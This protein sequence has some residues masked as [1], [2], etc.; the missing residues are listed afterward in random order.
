[1]GKISVV[2]MGGAE[3]E[4]GTIVLARDAKT[5]FTA[6]EVSDGLQL[7]MSIGGIYGGDDARHD[8]YFKDSS[9]ASLGRIRYGPTSGTPSGT[10]WQ[11]DFAATTKFI[12]EKDPTGYSA[13]IFH[14]FI[15]KAADGTL[16]IYNST[17]AEPLLS[18]VSSIE[19][20]MSD[21]YCVRSVFISFLKEA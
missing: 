6:D 19:Y 12:M 20:D 10:V 3:K 11:C 17:G 4:L 18:G 1:M 8:V 2:R 7:H 16:D 21:R 9:G 13:I 14:L 5:S 15:R